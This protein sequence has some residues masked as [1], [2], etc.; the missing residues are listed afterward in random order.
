MVINIDGDR[1]T[2]QTISRTGRVVDSG[3]IERRAE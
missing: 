1:L 3:V 2:F